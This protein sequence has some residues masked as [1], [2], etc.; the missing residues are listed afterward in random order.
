MR[1][2]VGLL[3]SPPAG[4]SDGSAQAALDREVETDVQF[5]AQHTFS[6]FIVGI[7]LLVFIHQ[8]A[9]CF[10]QR[11]TKGSEYEAPSGHTRGC[12]GTQDA[13]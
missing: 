11:Q 4:Q 13:F 12:E 2:T 1:V 6:P 8:G 7:G 3:V 10:W 9:G 5:D